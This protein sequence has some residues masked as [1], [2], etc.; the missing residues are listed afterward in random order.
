MALGPTRVPPPTTNPPESA[1]TTT[2]MTTITL[3][4]ER[5]IV[6]IIWGRTIEA[7]A[8]SVSGTS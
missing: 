5:G 7:T 1:R 8:P 3:G 4:G 6:A 2:A